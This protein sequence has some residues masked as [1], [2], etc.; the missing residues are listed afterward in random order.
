M[1]SSSMS[2]AVQLVDTP[3]AEFMAMKR[4]SPCD[5]PMEPLT[6]TRVGLMMVQLGSEKDCS[7]HCSGVGTSA[8]GAGQYWRCRT[9]DDAAACR[10]S[11]RVKLQAMPRSVIL[12]QEVGIRRRE[13]VPL[14]AAPGAGSHFIRGARAERVM[15]KPF[16]HIILAG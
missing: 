8:S 13:K 15:P 6:T 9:T 10:A 16:N 7:M 4:K 14:T 3:V 1:G 5:P 12:A 2:R 11:S